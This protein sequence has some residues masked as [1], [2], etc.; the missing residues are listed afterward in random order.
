MPSKGK[1]AE[2]NQQMAEIRAQNQK[3][4]SSDS[5]TVAHAQ[6][7]QDRDSRADQLK[8][9]LKDEMNP[10]LAQQQVAGEAILNT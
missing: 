2:H 8:K 6:E 7:A 5:A 1:I 10:L 4:T 3:T 9:L